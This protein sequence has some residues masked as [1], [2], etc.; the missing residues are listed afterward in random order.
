M[1]AQSRVA[2]DEV[3]EVKELKEVK[4]RKISAIWGR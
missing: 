2:R 3:E 1:K 4:D